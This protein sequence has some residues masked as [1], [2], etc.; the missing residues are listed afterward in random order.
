[1]MKEMPRKRFIVARVVT[2]GGI[3]VP[4]MTTPFTNPQ[5]APLSRAAG[6]ARARLPVAANTAPKTM[7]ASCRM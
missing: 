5:A 1:M 6:T 7:A 3:F 2:S 4:A